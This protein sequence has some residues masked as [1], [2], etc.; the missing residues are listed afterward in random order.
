MIYSFSTNFGDALHSST[1]SSYLGFIILDHVEIYVALNHIFSF[2][3]NIQ[4]DTR[5]ANIWEF[6]GWSRSKNGCLGGG[7]GCLQV[8]A[9]H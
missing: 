3:F 6:G 7:E 8:L 5:D 9:I 4:L 2:S 1:F